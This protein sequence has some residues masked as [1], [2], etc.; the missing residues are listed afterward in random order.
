MQ[1][2]PVDL[3][4]VCT[5]KA[6][7]DCY[8]AI[9]GAGE[10]AIEAGNL[11]K[12]PCEVID[13]ILTCAGVELSE[14][15]KAALQIACRTIVGGITGGVAGAGAG[16]ASGLGGG[17]G[18]LCQLISQYVNVSATLPPASLSGGGGF[19]GWSVNFAPYAQGFGGS[20]SGGGGNCSSPASPAF[21]QASS[22]TTVKTAAA[23]PSSAGVCARV[24]IR[25]EQEAVMTRAAFLG[26]LEIE[27]EGGSGLTGIRVDLDFRDEAGNS[28]S[29]RFAIRGP[30]LTG[31]SDVAG[32]GTIASGASGA[33][34]YTFIPT[35]EAAPTAPA[36]YRI[37]GTLRYIEN[38]VEVVA[39]LLSSTITV[40][41]EASI[42]LTYFQQRDVYSDDPFTTIVEPAEPFS[43]GLIA[44]NVGAGAAKNF[45]I[46]SA[47]PEIIENEKGLL[48]DF[49]I[50]GTKVGAQ[51]LSPTLTA[52]LGNIAPG[53]AQVAQWS[54]L[55]SLQGKFIEY[56]AT[57][58]HIDSLGGANLSLIDSV[59]IHELIHP[60]RADRA[61]DDAVPDF[62]VNDEPDAANLPDRLYLSDGS[63]SI[64]DLSLNPQT[65][66]PVTLGDFQVTLTANM[67]SGWNYFRLPDPGAGYR[68]YRV[69]RS[70]SRE[71][72][73]GDNVWT[74]D[75]SFPASQ[76]GVL[77]E[78]LL[79]MLDFNGTGSYTLYYRVEDSVAPIVLDVVDVVP[80]LQTAPVA[81]VDV[82]LSERI[83]PATFTYQDVILTLNGGTN[84]ITSAVTVSFVSNATYRIGGLAPLT[85]A[86]GNYELT[87]LGAGIRDYGDNA[88]TNVVSE[89]WAKG[90][91]APVI[92]TVGPVTPDPRTNALS[93]IDVV[94]SRAINATTFTVTDL[95]L[96]RGGSAVP[97]SGVTITTLSSN[98]FRI[99][100]LDAL[101]AAEG[102]Y[103]LTVRALEVQDTDGN[104]GL[105]AL[106]D[107]WVTDV[108]RP[109]ITAIEQIATDP[110]S[111]AVQTLDVTLSEPIDP[112]T[113]DWHDVTL[114]RNG[115]PN[116]ITSEVGVARLDA[117]HYRISNFNWVVGNEGTYTLSVNAVGISDL[118]GNAG[119][120]SASESWVMDTTAPAAPANLAISPD[121]GVSATDGLS[122]TNA[123]LFSGALGETNLTV[124]LL[125]V[126]SGSD[127][128]TA[129]VTGTSF[130]KRL[131]FVG[132]GTHRIRARATDNA[133]NVSDAFFNIFIDLEKPEIVMQPIDPNPRT[134]SVTSVDVTF[135]EPINPGT[136]NL[137]DLTL[138]RHGGTNNL[139]TNVVSIQM[140]ASNLFRINGLDSLSAPVG[141]YELV[142]NAAGVED[143]AGNSALLSATNA[144][145]R[146]F[147]NSAPRLA[148]AP[149]Q[150]VD[151][152]SL[153][154]FTVVATDVDVPTNT[155]AFSLA[156]NSPI[157]AA[158]DPVTGQFSWTPSEAQGPQIV[159][160]TIRV[161]DDGAPNLTTTTNVTI[162]VRE[163]NL[164]PVLAAV[165]NHF[166][167]IDTL[168][169]V[170]NIASDADIPANTLT[171]SL[172]AGAP[173]GL[174]L[175]AT[176]GILTWRPGSQF[177]GTTNPVAVI[178][179][180]NGIPALS[181]TNTSLIVVGDYL[182]VVVGRAVMQSGQT[183]S[184]PVSVETSTSVTNVSV[185]VDLPSARLT[186]ATLTGLA[187]GV[188]AA[189]QPAGPDHVQ[190]RLSAATALPPGQPLAN[191]GFVATSNQPSAIIPLLVSGAQALQANG[192]AVPRVVGADGRVVIVGSQPLIEALIATNGQRMLV[193]YGQSNVTYDIESATNLNPTVV[194][195][196]YWRGGVT[197]LVQ[198]VVPNTG[199]RLFY[200]AHRP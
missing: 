185:I 91:V 29:D 196:L 176:S 136:F 174:E 179:T 129:L 113:F 175:D 192:V 65:D 173:A 118:A 48:I 18:C 75:R 35:R 138:T 107:S 36:I 140:I 52:N 90:A 103:S 50:I 5:A 124:R 39:P 150:S 3:S 106:T 133:G 193:L 186:N 112:A 1:A 187:P 119:V 44:K 63:V 21:A 46:T 114:T 19:P 53:G 137:A 20:F 130:S 33:A 184:V 93:S 121:R 13:A 95:A 41:P 189:L 6:A 108:T 64:V 128:G 198:P 161:T 117:L 188:T 180:D 143:L 169:S 197:N 170:T 154:T 134:N 172:G 115:G 86:D 89:T 82:I 84:L 101:T 155:L 139:I 87:V 26:S 8:E 2:R 123:P 60:V 148:T 131:E 157:G 31:L 167:I 159:T 183:S 71:L 156:P 132:G 37:G 23:P 111:I 58:E 4:P 12:A 78:H 80:D 68:L 141:T 195:T 109:A 165:P 127:L 77:R 57:F 30:Q 146:A 42:E 99:S 14:C 56:S 94:F 69:V 168:V 135:S 98:A 55:S 62:L 171:F 40:F 182:E 24:R 153:L 73:V 194:W 181:R 79:H 47:Q 32:G 105:G 152:G 102:A 142:V 160:V 126:T 100:G 164:R 43:L 88:G 27:N 145:Q 96:T 104:A 149:N 38:G 158:I 28:V 85:G 92:V 11:A 125:D 177:A 83:D 7:Y 178:V 72:R 67:S 25:I 116:L 199:Q 191:L 163:V 22:L 49:K 162:Q 110:R 45:R 122:N 147:P 16:A 17:L 9:K 144:W 120:G 190:L 10:A 54:F 15:Q 61:G 97:L 76:A 34:K 59:S 66:G 200:R 70:D 74:T 151:E 166:T 51:D 81:S